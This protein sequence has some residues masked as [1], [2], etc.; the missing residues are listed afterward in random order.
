MKRVNSDSL[1][2]PG[3]GRDSDRVVYDLDDLAA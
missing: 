3:S 2:V 1:R